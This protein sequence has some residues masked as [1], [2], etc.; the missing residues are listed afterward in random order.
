MI[1]LASREVA[2][3]VGQRAAGRQPGHGGVLAGKQPGC[4]RCGSRYL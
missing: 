3:P 2:E 1:E 4:A